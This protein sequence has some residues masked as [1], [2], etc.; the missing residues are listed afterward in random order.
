MAHS[1]GDVKHLEVND[2]SLASIAWIERLAS[3][4]RSECVV[5][6]VARA[7]TVIVLGMTWYHSVQPVMRPLWSPSSGHSC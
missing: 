6:A 3:I 7:A 5:V 4:V 1:M 2:A